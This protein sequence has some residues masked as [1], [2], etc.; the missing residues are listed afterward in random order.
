MKFKSNNSDIWNEYISFVPD[1]TIECNPPYIK[2]QPDG[3][4]IKYR[5]GKRPKTL[6]E[7]EQAVG[8]K[9]QKVL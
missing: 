9:L 6:Q 4:W 3:C 5:T 8:M 1:V 7:F 2:G